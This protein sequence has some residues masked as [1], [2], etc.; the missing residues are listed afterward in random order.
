MKTKIYDRW[1]FGA[2][3]GAYTYRYDKRGNL[4]EELRGSKVLKSYTFDETNRLALGE[5]GQGEQSRY[6]YNGVGMRVRTEQRVHNLNAGHQD[7]ANSAG[8]QHVGS[9]ED[10][11]SKMALHPEQ[12]WTSTVGSTRQTALA[13]VNRDYVIDWNSPHHTD[14]M[15]I[16]EKGYT[17]RYVY[18]LSKIYQETTHV[19]GITEPGSEGANVRSAVATE[20]LGK[21]YVHED[22]LSTPAYFTKENAKVIAY[23]QTDEWGKP[24]TPAVLELNHSGLDE[25]ADYTGHTYDRVLGQYFA[26]ARMYDPV[27]KRF[28]SEDTYEGNIGNP[29]SLNWYTYVENNPLI[30]VDPSGHKLEDIMSIKN[31]KVDPIQIIIMGNTVSM[32][33]HVTIY[34]DAADKQLGDTGKTYRE[35]AI[36][37]MASYWSGSYSNVFGE[38]IE[39]KLNIVDLGKGTHL[40][41]KD[42]KSVL[43]NIADEV[44]ISNVKYSS[45]VFGYR[46]WTK[47]SVGKTTLYVGDDRSNIT[48]PTF[49]ENQFMWVAAHELGH[50]LGVTDAYSR[51][52]GKTITS[53]FNK[54]ET[55]V[56]N[57]DIEKVLKAFQ[58][59][60]QQN[61]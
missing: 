51:K 22:L 59:N 12:T 17:Q 21:L 2:S 43:I 50:N 58:K 31:N 25:V 55:A 11:T 26:Q 8:S 20:L 36:E 30:Y 52:G 27:N 16:E 9:V 5:N 60:K 3:D 18:G 35:W 10:L 56:Q 7:G 38:A 47:S 46:K 6:I 49:N 19:P 32:N 1:L 15:A 42:Q 33:I 61:W 37:G 54:F 48:Y 23:A 40:T 29:L 13:Q 53:I 4:V 41:Q 44:N 45:N 28:I 39:V 24:L 14:L 34:G 57:I